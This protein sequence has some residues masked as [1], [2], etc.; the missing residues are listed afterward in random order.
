MNLPVT[1]FEYGTIQ[2]LSHAGLVVYLTGRY[3]SETSPIS[4]WWSVPRNA[5][6]GLF[7]IS[8]A[9]IQDGTFELRQL[10]LL[11]VIYFGFDQVPYY[12]DR[13]P[14]Q[15]RL[16]RLISEAEEAAQWEK[17]R[18]STDEKTY[19]QARLYARD[20]K[21]P[22][23]PALTKKIL[24]LFEKYPC[25]WV[26]RAMRRVEVLRPDNPRKTIHYVEGILV[27]FAQENG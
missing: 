12:K 1:F 24:E 20:L 2:T 22:R 3:L 7:K 21:D 27:G 17:I 9:V 23:D 19:T 4:P 5:W 13:P 14:N 8:V 6:A 11:E 16:N 15:Y 26:A 10:N 25:P 18:G